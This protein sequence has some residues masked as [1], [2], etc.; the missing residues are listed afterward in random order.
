MAPRPLLVAATARAGHHSATIRSPWDGA[1]VADVYLA[2]PDEADEAAHAA[3]AC[4]PAFSRTPTHERRSLLEAVAG[5]LRERVDLFANAIRGE[6]G[7]PITLARAEVLRA[8]ETFHLMAGEAERLGGELIPIDLSA[9]T[10]GY[11]C[12]ARPVPRGPALAIGPFNFPLNL[13]AHK[14]APA[15]AAGCPVVVKPPPQAPTAALL[16]GELMVEKAPSHWPRGFLSVLPCA[17]DVAS[18]LAAD[19]RFRV[20]SFTGS[21]PVGWR[22]RQLA[23]KAHVVLELGGDAGVIVCE[24][25]DLETAAKR[26]AWGASA[27]AGQVCVSVQRIFVQSSVRARFTAFLVE[28]MRAIVSGDP[29]DAAT[30]SGPMI[31]DRAA[32]RIEALLSG[33][34][35]LAGG[36]RAGRLIAPALVD[37]PAQKNPIAH[38]EVFGPVAGVWSFD[39]FEEALEQVEASKFGLQAGLY[40]RDVG[41]IFA[42]HDRLR[43]GGLVVNDVPTLRV[44]SYPY[45]GTKGSGAGREGGRHGVLEYTEPRV[46]VLNAGA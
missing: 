25:A 44:D 38:D 24:D 18:Q 22:I 40:T 13:L 23:A 34:N 37:E 3:N 9:A 28:A 16:L 32:D 20:V 11:R 15:L 10:E 21:G 19:E 7:K 33:A 5:G 1:V 42:A 2:S 29:S 43:V 26:I 27:Y 14:V 46:L 12:L 30:V 39:R 41:R 36:A 8:A 45:G 6:A 17:N 4:A 35:V 31:D